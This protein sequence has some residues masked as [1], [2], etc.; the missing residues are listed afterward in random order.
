M[1][2]VVLFVACLLSVIVTFAQRTVTGRV[3]DERGNPVPSASVQVKGTTTGTTARADG[4]FSLTLPPDARTLVITYIGFEDI[5]V[6]IGANQTDF[7]I[8][9]KP[10]TGAELR[11]VVV[12]A[13][14]I[15]RDKRA[16][17]YATTTLKTDQI[18]NKGDANLVNVLQG[19]VA[20]VN[21]TSA[22]GSPGASA[23]INIRGITSFLQSNQP[24][25]VVD[26]IP[27][28]NDVDR[29]VGGPISTLGDQQPANRILDLNLANV[30]SVN[31]LK[32]PAAAVLY[33]SR[34][35]SGAII[36][37]TRKG[38]GVK[39]KL[40]VSL[41]TSYGFQ[42]QNGLPEFQNEYG[43]GL[44]GVFNPISGNSF[45]PRFGTTPTLINGLINPATGQPYPYE[46]HKDNIKD[47]FETGSIFDNNLTINS[48]DAQQNFALNVGH[49]EQKGII[50][51]TKFQRSNIQFA[52][53]TTFK[54]FRLGGTVTYSNSRQNGVLGGNSAGGGTGWGY[55]VAIPRSFDLQAFK[56]D[57][58][59]PDGSQKFP[60]LANNVEN[61]YF[62]AYE[63]PV[64]SQLSRVTGN[65]VMGYDFTSWLKLDYRI[66]VDAYTDRRKQIFAVTSRVRPT[67]QVLEDVFYRNEIS[68][69]LMLNARKNDIFTEGLNVS[70]LL[71]HN[72][73]Q[74]RLQNVTARGDNLTIPGYYNLNNATV[75]T[76]GTAEGSFLNR[77][78][79]W[80]AQASFDWNNYLFLELTGRVD[81]SSTLP[82]GKN[83]YLY[84]SIAG[85]FVFTDAFK[86][87]SN[88]LS[89][90][91]L[92]VS[93]A[94]VGRDAPPYVLQ[95]V[96]SSSTFGNNVSGV[97]FP[98]TIGGTPVT[99]F[100]VAATIANPDLKPEFTTSYEVG[101][102]LG[103]FKNKITLDVAYFDEVSKDQILQVA[104]PSS[105]GFG[106]RFANVGKMTNKGVEIGITAT[107]ISNKN[108]RWDVTG[109]FTHIKNR[110][111]EIFD[112]I[113]NFPISSGQSFTGVVASIALNQPYGVI[114]GN[115]FPR[116]PS[117]DIIINPAT[118]LPA[119]GVPNQV[120]SD[121]N[122]DFTAGLTNTFKYKNFTF[123]FLFDLTYGNELYSFTIPALRG[124]GALK[125]T[126]V[127]REQPMIFPGV[128][129]TEPNK[130]VPNNIQI[131]AQTYW[132]AGGLASE[133][134]VFDATVLKLRELA[135]SYDLPNTILQKTPFSLVRVGLFGR[136][137]FYYAPNYPMDPEVN[138]QGAGNLRGMDL[139]GAP[140]ARTLGASLKFSFK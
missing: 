103:L 77:I 27:I 25:F 73:N 109:N 55:L 53:N 87:K 82:K 120:L 1:K 63:N 18:A 122:P 20:G 23:N 105:T 135:L 124:A 114:I 9:L 123:S 46:L 14:G 39:G 118:G 61:P 8:S 15:S 51:N 12:T 59:N 86:M 107:P 48:G 113:Q 66:G 72:I 69:D 38:S 64:T 10:K 136:N 128:I 108:F 131:P 79:G 132:R 52:G 93:A 84:P 68:S 85:S 13:Q 119:A 97:T 117:G 47:F 80:Y 33:G 100:S 95:N 62:T 89:Y 116:S 140:N 138:T 99:G 34:A 76:N 11:E 112:D 2:K 94:R 96:Y 65:I 56:N 129:Q 57:Y 58:K 21:I 90:G 74:R 35:S 29:T 43:Q 60:L 3:T 22:S 137:V 121:P 83:T 49:F 106:A 111:E 6:T 31:I 70:L 30:E 4:R 115:K 134:S 88:T 54:K 71:G 37:T 125:E 32:G 130:Y 44:N 67:G 41:T 102:N 126:A 110:V 5:E 98:V 75:F 91:K 19:K 127:N 45:G 36:I 50:P 17:G 26:G 28:S 7:D 133:L 16:L 139:Q 24:L 81:Q 104:V 40:D 92:R 78:V 42:N 101:L